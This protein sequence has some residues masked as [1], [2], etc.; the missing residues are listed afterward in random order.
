MKDK[1]LLILL[2]AWLWLRRQMQPTEAQ[3]NLVMAAAVG[4]TG[5]VLGLLFRGATITLQQWLTQGHESGV[6]AFATL[7]DWAKLVVPTLG[8]LVAGLVLLYGHKFF[9][10]KNADYMEAIMLGDG[11]LPIKSSLYRS[12]AA[13]FSIATGASIGREG[14]MV[15]LAALGGSIMGEW[16]NF[17]PARRRLIVA[18][19]A[20][21][22]I[23][24]AYNAPIAGALFVSEI[25]VGSLTMESLGPLIFASVTSIV[26]VHI[27]SDA[28][29]LYRLGSFAMPRPGEL[30][31]FGVLGVACGLMAGLFLTMLNYLKKWFQGVPGPLP[32]RMALGGLAVGIIAMAH[33][34]VTGNGY[35]VVKSLVQEKWV[36]QV[37]IVTLVA[38]MLATSAS[39]GSGAVGGVFTPTLVVGSCTGFLCWQGF[40]ALFPDLRLDQAGFAT[41]GM[42]AVLA[43]ATQ[44]PFMSILMIFEMTLSYEIMIPLMLASVIGYYTF[45]SLK[46]HSL[47]H[48]A[49][50]AYDLFSRPLETL[51]VADIMQK[52]P[53]TVRPEASFGEVARKFVAGGLDRQYLVG[54]GG[55][56]LGV[57]CLEDMTEHLHSVG[58][59]AAFIAGD[60]ARENSP[61]LDPRTPLPEALVKF[62][63]EH[64][65]ELPIVESGT[66]RLVGTLSRN[67]LLL[68]L[69]EAGK[70][71]ARGR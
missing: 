49:P 57:V 42:G 14:P 27:F 58:L 12:L 38:K 17:P 32:L 30:L 26:T 60:I 50:D 55:K 51:T 15:Q 36:W 47:Y 48:A 6:R 9:R 5:A 29:P 70:R 71:G 69:A 33:P 40:A 2:R 21:A 35:E 7:P 52:Q 3:W 66:D 23:A 10:Q 39:F 37:V 24:A 28:G 11:K 53:H 19:G 41:I 67:D 4:G 22:G 8:G 64:E 45:R 31:C 61:A 43:A 68:T 59:A 46:M 20:A 44:A 62:T 54:K 56:L 65:Q 34:D 18:S 63:H 25:T 1:N 13:L 16:R